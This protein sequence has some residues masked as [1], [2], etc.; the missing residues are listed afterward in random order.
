MSNGWGLVVKNEI[1]FSL[2]YQGQKRAAC[3]VTWCRLRLWSER[4][5]FRGTEGERSKSCPLG[6]Q[7]RHFSHW[8]GTSPS[9]SD[10]SCSWGCPSLSSRR[11]P[12]REVAHG[13]L[14]VRASDERIGFHITATPKQVLCFFHL[15][16]G[17]HG[18]E[19]KEKRS[20]AKK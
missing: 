13:E 15:P 7:P 11:F 14:F 19:K 5:E 9:P 18:K 6:M 4:P 16:D 3:L 12:Q 17:S 2:K 1:G 20:Y 10:W 8:R